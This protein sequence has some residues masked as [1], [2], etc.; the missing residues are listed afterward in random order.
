[1][2]LPGSQFTKGTRSG[3]CPHL[4]VGAKLQALSKALSFGAQTRASGPTRSKSAAHKM[5]DLQ[6]VAVGELY[7]IPALAGNEVAVKFD[8]DAV[9]LHAKLIE[10]SG[11]G[12]YRTE[13][14]VF[15][16]DDEFHGRTRA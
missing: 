8:R 1:M 4:P 15:A 16:V 5:D 12:G 10:K 3:G 14:A 2:E 7:F 6:L 13:F 11:Y 9:G